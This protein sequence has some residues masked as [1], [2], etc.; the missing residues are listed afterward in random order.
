[1][2]DLKTN[3]I[4][5]HNDFLKKSLQIFD[6]MFIF[7]FNFKNIIENKKSCFSVKLCEIR[8]KN[9]FFSLNRESQFLFLDCKYR[10]RSASVVMRVYTSM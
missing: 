5:M 8:K 1:M 2:R 3:I 9:T 6:K 4:R 10:I 7:R